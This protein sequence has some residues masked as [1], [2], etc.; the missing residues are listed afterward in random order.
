MMTLNHGFSGYICAKVAAPLL[1]KH[2]P[3]PEKT[4]ALALFLGAMLPDLDIIASVWGRSAYFSGAWYG[5]RQLSHSVAGTLMLAIVVSIPLFF[6]LAPRWQPNRGRSWLWMVGM[7]WAGGWVHIFGDFFTPARKMPVFWPLELQLGGLGHIGWFN[8]YLLWLF[9]AAILIG[10]VL[11]LIPKLHP[12]AKSWIGW[13]VWGWFGLAAYRWVNFFI[14]SR[15]ESYSQ[16]TD[17]QRTLLPEAMITP[18]TEGV[19]VLWYWLTR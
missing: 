11:Q 17:F 4:F 15:Y 12:P 5:H 16:W 14:T 13:A 8:P 7:L 19:R 10:W 18:V 2:C 9:V 1:K 3:F 6:L